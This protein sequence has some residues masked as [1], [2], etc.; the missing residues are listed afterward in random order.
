MTCKACLMKII[1]KPVFF[2]YHWLNQFW[3]R[4]SF[5][6]TSGSVQ[7][8]YFS[9]YLK[10]KATSMV[11]RKSFVGSSHM[12]GDGLD[13]WRLLNWLFWEAIVHSHRSQHYKETF[14]FL[15]QEKSDKN[16]SKAGKKLDGKRRETRHRLCWKSNMAFSKCVKKGLRVEMCHR[17]K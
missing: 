10:M 2:M 11:A 17:K 3:M 1:L 13:R 9:L 5:C 6:P 7:K 12:Y 8:L 14:S 16:W 15:N 4:L